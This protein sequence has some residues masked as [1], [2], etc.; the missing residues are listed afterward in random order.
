ML[1]GVME[2]EKRIN[3]KILLP[4]LLVPLLAG[5]LTAWA[6]GD[7]FELYKLLYK[8]LFSPPGALF[9][10]IWTILYAM[11]GAASYFVLSSDAG[12][13]R[14]KRAMKSYIVQLGLNL[15]WPL[16]FFGAEMFT[17][18]LVTAFA[19]L[20]AAM[21]CQVFFAHISKTAGNLLL[22]YVLW[23]FYALYLNAGVVL[24]N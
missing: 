20:A 13:P 5:G 6:V 12:K 14:K 19:L 11:M 3:Y 22:P 18:A 24:L 21:L 9:P 1:T 2:L 17:L 8:P 10:I 4:A 7:G 15:L 16:L 23:L